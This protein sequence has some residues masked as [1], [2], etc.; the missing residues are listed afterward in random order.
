MIN[1]KAVIAVCTPFRLVPRSLLISVILTFMLE[2]RGLVAAVV[3]L[4]GTQPTTLHE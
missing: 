4:A 3:P 1:M 2:P